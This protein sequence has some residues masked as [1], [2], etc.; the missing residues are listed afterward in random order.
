MGFPYA[1]LHKRASRSVLD[2][3][4]NITLD[5]SIP[6]AGNALRNFCLPLL[7]VYE[8]GLLRQTT[9][10]LALLVDDAASAWASAAADLLPASLRVAEK[11][12]SAHWQ[13]ALRNEWERQLPIRSASIHKV[14]LVAPP[15]AATGPLCRGAWVT[16]PKC[17]PLISIWMIDAHSYNK[18][19]PALLLSIH[20]SIVHQEYRS[21]FP[22]G[23]LIYFVNGNVLSINVDGPQLRRVAYN[24]STRWLSSSHAFGPRCAQAALNGLL[25]QPSCRIVIS[26]NNS[27]LT[28]LDAST[29]AESS[30]FDVAPT[31]PSGCPSWTVQD[32]SWSHDG[33]AI[34]IVLQGIR[35]MSYGEAEQHAVHV[36]EAASGDLL[37]KLE[38]LFLRTSTVWSSTCSSLA[39]FSRTKHLITG[40]MSASGAVDL[41][42]LNAVTKDVMLLPCTVPDVPGARW[43]SAMWL[44]CGELLAVAW[45]FDT[46]PKGGAILDPAS[47]RPVFIWT[48][49][50]TGARF[51]TSADISTFIPKRSYAWRRESARCAA[52]K[53]TYVRSLE[54]GALL[55]LSRNKGAWHG[56][57]QKVPSLTKV[58]IAPDAAFMVGEHLSQPYLSWWDM[59][60][61]TKTGQLLSCSMRPEP[62]PRLQTALLEWAPFLFWPAVFACVGAIGQTTT[63]AQFEDSHELTSQASAE[64]GNGPS[65]EKNANDILLV[66]GKRGLLLKRLTLK[67]LLSSAA[68]SDHVQLRDCDPHCLEW[69]PDGKHL[70]VYCKTCVIV[71]SFVMASEPGT[72]SL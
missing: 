25:H 36:Y 70:G 32:L 68:S 61:E 43:Y 5:T 13:A 3:I 71:V 19:G 42:V 58:H 67:Q 6:E 2:N 12:T 9:R 44:P 59:R 66:D 40:D 11:A 69:S 34:A 24:L 63:A 39:V 56:H 26:K 62:V 21:L 47:P 57:V 60:F 51:R 37:M 10:N 53:V 72:T 27:T 48:Q 65:S 38:D 45:R 17:P 49:Q 7:S 14:N 64:L 55:C 46:G 29:F 23:S 16:G 41:Y 35:P 28:I 4:M 18:P 30:H 15:Y 33:S 52:L 22:S 54:Q 31:A 8:L 1:P 20:D 50:D